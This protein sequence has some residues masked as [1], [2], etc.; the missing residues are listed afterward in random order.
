MLKGVPA[1]IPPELLMR[2]CELGHGDE[3]TI[4]DANF[5]AHSYCDNVIR[6]DGHGV[7]EILDAIL[8]LIPL[9]Q[10]V[11]H[12]I[13]VMAIPED[14]GIDDPITN[15]YAE[16]AMKHEGKGDL[17]EYVDRFDFYDRV[18]NKS[19]FVIMSGEKALY[20]NIVIK[21]GVI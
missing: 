21:K 6:M 15:R 8:Q 4:G 5:P 9:D 12:P 14:A 16:I 13:T 7:P 3:F 10:Y 19:L 2:L 20:A 11:D 1:I 18:K 17:I